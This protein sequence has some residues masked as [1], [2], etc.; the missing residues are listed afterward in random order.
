MIDIIPS[1][2]NKIQ[3]TAEDLKAMQALVIDGLNCPHSKVM[4][5]EVI[6]NFLT[7]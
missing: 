2:E 3:L 5:G 1:S 6:D 4:Y 7:W